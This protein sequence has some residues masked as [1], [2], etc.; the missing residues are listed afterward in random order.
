M[1]K[2]MEKFMNAAE[3]PPSGPRM[4]MAT[5]PS[6]TWY[7]GEPIAGRKRRGLGL[8]DWRSGIGGRLL[9]GSERSVGL[10]G[11]FRPSVRQ[12]AAV[13]KKED[14]IQFNSPILITNALILLQ[15]FLPSSPGF[16]ACLFVGG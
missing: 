7:A 9:G 13:G 5:H 6:M 15:H 1:K 16:V 4:K 12:K 11:I 2:P 8:C 10:A 14:V 3:T